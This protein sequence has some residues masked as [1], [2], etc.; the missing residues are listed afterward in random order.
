MPLFVDGTAIEV[1]G[2][3]FEQAG[4]GYNGER[5]NWLHS[6]CVG[7]LWVSARLEPGGSDV[8]GG[9]REQF[10]LDVSGLVP[11]GTPVW[12]RADNA[13]YRGE[14]AQYCQQRGWDYSISLTNSRNQAPIARRLQAC[15]FSDQDWVPLDEDGEQEAQLLI[16][17]PSGWCREQA[18][19]V[20][21]HHRSANSQRRLMPNLSM[22]LV[23][24]HD[25]SLAE[26]VQRH[27]AEQGQE[28]AFKGP[29]TALN[30]HHSPCQSYAANQAYYLCGQL[31]QLLRLVPYQ[32]LPDQ[33]R[34]HGLGP[35]IRG[36]V[37]T[38]ARLTQSGRRTR[39]RYSRSNYRSDWLAHAMRCLEPPG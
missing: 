21:R 13:C 12:V 39:V 9:W 27:R 15:E 5:Q 22:I 36:L 1:Q 25:L 8:A 6:V 23:S 37:R 30:L 35:L 26:M 7:P 34:K 10:E 18:Y 2:Q 19:V 17:R 4:R 20:I 16:Y 11:P 38:V 32:L 24:R 33:A 31:A 14:L 3:H 28:N 29:L